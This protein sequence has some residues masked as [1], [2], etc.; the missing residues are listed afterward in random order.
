MTIHSSRRLARRR[1]RRGFSIV[2]LIVGV[3]LLGVG[4]LALAGT[5]AVVSRL[6]QQGGTHVV[7]TN[8]ARARFEKLRAQRCPVAA[9]S[10]TSFR[11]TENWAVL[12]SVPASRLYEVRDSLAYT[13]RGKN[14]S[15]IYRSY[16]VC[17]P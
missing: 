17:Q 12:S 11:V 13:V 4:V 6:L 8:L 1:A 2:E 5:S 10:A 15:Q 14:K 7:V 3:T 9:G 16:V